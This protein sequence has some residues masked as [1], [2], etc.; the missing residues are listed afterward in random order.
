MRRT[1]AIPLLALV[2]ALGAGGAASAQGARSQS[3]TPTGLIT[4]SQQPGAT[5]ASVVTY[6]PATGDRAGSYATPWAIYDSPD[7]FVMSLDH[8]WLAQPFGGT[9][10]LAH[11]SGGAYQQVHVWKPAGDAHLTS[12]QFT[13]GGNLL[14]ASATGYRDSEK[15]TAAYLVDPR[16]PSAT[17]VRQATA[18][19]YWNV[20]GQPAAWAPQQPT[21]MDSVNGRDVAAD[22]LHTA[23]Q[24]VAARFTSRDG[25]FTPYRCDEI[26]D[27][28]HTVCVADVDLATA[29]GYSL[30]RGVV[31]V[32]DY[33][34][35][36]SGLSMTTLITALPDHTAPAAPERFEGAYLSPDTTTILIATSNGWYRA[37]T[38]STPQVRYAFAHLGGTA[39]NPLNTAILGWGQFHYAGR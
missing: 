17:P 19:R 11:L 33:G 26:L 10:R 36:V 35:P 31:A 21:D 29:R 25:G 28:T 14:Y 37:D 34:D 6:D 12:P 9:I 4:V 3:T 5:T 39:L 1:F 20:S 23:G 32:G 30:P 22:I 18:T 7:E 2:L 15:V 13:S 8:Q 27:P 16:D 24:L 38:S